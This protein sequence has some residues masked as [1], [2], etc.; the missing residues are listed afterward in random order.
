MKKRIVILHLFVIL[1]FGLGVV[2]QDYQKIAPKTPPPQTGEFELPKKELPTG[3]EEKVLVKALRGLVF[4]AKPDKIRKKGRPGIMGVNPYDL[5]LLESDDFKKSMEPYFG[6]PVSM[7]SLNQITRDVVLYYR[8]KGHPVVEVTVPEQDITSGVVQVVVLEAV[9]GE[10]RIEGNKWFSSRLLLSNLR[11]KPGEHV[12]STQLTEDINWLNSNPFRQ[13]DVVF[14]PGKESGQTDLVMKVKDRF[15]LRVYTGYED[16]GN[17]LT[18]DERILF[19]ANWGNAFLLGHQFNYQYTADGNFNK[20]AAHSGSYVAPLPWRHR[21]TIFGSYADTVAD[22]PTAFGLKGHSWQA[23]ARY[24][25]P[26]PTIEKYVQEFTAGFDFKKSNNNLEIVGAGTAFNNTTDILQWNAGYN[27]GLRDPW[28]NTGLGVNFFYSPGALTDKNSDEVFNGAARPTFVSAPRAF[29]RA[30]Y[31]YS[32]INIDRVTRLPYDFTWVMKGTYQYSDANLLGSEQ[33]GIGGYSTVRG[34]DER[35]ANG[36]EGYIFSTELRTPSIS[37]GKLIGLSK[38]TD[39]F[40]FLYFYDYGVAQNKRLARGED[41]SV[42]L[43][44]TGPGFRY[45]INPYLSAR[46]DYGFQLYDTGLNSRYNSRWHIGLVL[47]Y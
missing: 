23:S 6:Q 16:T 39:Q 5:P 9:L 47:S 41:P 12:E 44:G 28:G 26:L 22:A 35:E 21:L 8:Q 11:V 45:T 43:A 27:S 30:S 24:S 38:A 20:L 7:K 31:I 29:S 40:Q 33:L 37:P 46:A 4:E 15:P 19:G 25:I 14:T 13:T 36:D 17:N 18:G 34:Y 42:L 1:F 10:A 3:G 2:A 32:K